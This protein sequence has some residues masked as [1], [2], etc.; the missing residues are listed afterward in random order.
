MDVKLVQDGLK[1]EK[2]E[3]LKGEPDYV[4]FRSSFKSVE[5]GTVIIGKKIV[6]GF[7][8]IKRIF[9]LENGLKKNMPSHVL[10]A[11]EKIDGFNVRIA[12]VAGKIYAFSRGGFLDAFVT[13]KTKVLGLEQFFKENPDYVLCGEMVGNTPYTEPTKDFDVKL[14]VFDI[15]RGDGS[16][17]PCEKRYAVLK[18]YGI[19]SAPMLGKFKSNDYDG[20]RK[21]ILSLNMGRREGMVLKSADRKYIVKYVTPFADIDDIHKTSE[22]FFDMP[23]GFYYQ[24]VL[25][26]AFFINDFGFDKE[27]YSAMLGK[28]F[29]DGLNKALQK[30]KDGHEI[31]E[32]FEILI[33]DKGIWKDVQRHMSKDVRLEELWRREEKGK[34]RIRFRKIYKRTTR[35]LASYAAGKG[36]TD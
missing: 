11:E 15:D 24:R 1:R 13:E 7:P 23:I 26:S 30:V 8:H 9:T 2:A 36:I 28:A 35:K 12:T 6:W 3:R 31:D 21:L 18:K 32:E 14:F 17:L 16:Y 27:K 34:T 29:Y 33:K 19:A 4:R 20:L 5:R 10:Y 25:R 22:L